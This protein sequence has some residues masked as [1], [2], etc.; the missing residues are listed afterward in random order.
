MSIL[1][2]LFGHYRDGALYEPSSPD[3]VRT[4]VNLLNIQKGVKAVDLGSGDGRIVIEMARRGAEAYGFENDPK[5]VEESRVNIKK[6]GLEKL[7]HI[8]EGN[9]WEQDLSSFSRISVFQWHTIM[10]RLEEKLEKEL[11]PESFI[12]SHYWKFPNWK[13]IAEEG[14]IYLYKKT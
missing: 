13:P 4:I 14:E 7:A 1:S 2:L 3:E 6:E 12:V 8:Q 10:G 9:F 5:L 11:Q